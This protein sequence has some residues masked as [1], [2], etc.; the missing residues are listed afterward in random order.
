MK[1]SQLTITKSLAAEYA[2][3]PP[4]HKVLADRI[5]ARDPGNAPASGD[6]IGF[7]YVKAAAGQLANKLQGDRIETP[8]FIEAKGLKPD[9]EYY[10][11]H[12]L[13]N[14]LSQLFGI[15]LEQMPGYQP[16]KKWADDEDKRIAQREMM[17]G[18]LL[19]REGLQACSKSA[20]QDFI[21]K[22]M[23]GSVTATGASS[24]L[25]APSKPKRVATGAFKTSPPVAP[26]LAAAAPKKQ[27]LINTFFK[28]S[29]CVSDAVLAR[30]MRATKRATRKTS[31]SP[32]P[33]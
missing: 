7:V 18:D 5:A 15:L 31:A 30:E 8:A 21:H 12:Q 4:A 28:E 17:A 24:Q 6:R 1:L 29:S 11:E 22:F 26:E 13:M 2:A 3:S 9:A 23:G 16:P 19:F 33:T 27:A 14:P 32:P 25:P 10:I 20:T